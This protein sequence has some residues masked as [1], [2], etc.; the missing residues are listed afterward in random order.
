MQI[1]R[2]QL[3]GEPPVHSRSVV[4][5]SYNIKMTTQKIRSHDDR[6]S[7]TWICSSSPTMI[8]SIVQIYM[9]PSQVFQTKAHL[10]SIITLSMM[11]SRKER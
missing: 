10:K 5:I 3:G 11:K 9:K 8:Y 4:K 2:R 6:R 1:R 7:A